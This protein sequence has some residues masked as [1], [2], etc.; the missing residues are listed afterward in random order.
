MTLSPRRIF[1]LPV[2]ALLCFTSNSSAQNTAYPGTTREVVITPAGDIV[3]ALDAIEKDLDRLQREPVAASTINGRPV[4]GVVVEDSPLGVEVV[5]VVEGSAAAL[6]GLMQG[7]KIIEIDQFEIELPT[8]MKRAVE[9][10]PTGKKMRLKWIRH[11][12]EM[13]H[14]IVFVAPAIEDVVERPAVVQMH[15]DEL[16]H[17]IAELRQ[18]VR[19][20]TQAVKALA[21]LQQQNAVIQ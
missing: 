12:R 15:H 3:V 10:H 17:E 7:D 16:H 4:L 18:Q 13:D 5:S 1:A 21:M 14:E 2:I 20:L 8:D 19:V 11:N 9:I 6:A